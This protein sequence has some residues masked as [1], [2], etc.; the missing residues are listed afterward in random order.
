M[1]HVP[2]PAAGAILAIG[3]ISAGCTPDHPHPVLPELHPE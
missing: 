1:R 2:I 3:A